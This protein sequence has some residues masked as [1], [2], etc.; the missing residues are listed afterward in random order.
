MFNGTVEVFNG[1]V[2]VFNGTVEVFNGTVEV[3]NGQYWNVIATL[4]N[5]YFGLHL[6]FHLSPSVLKFKPNYGKIVKI[7]IMFFVL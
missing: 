2:E 7:L 5:D 3:F 4:Q 6:S 1:T